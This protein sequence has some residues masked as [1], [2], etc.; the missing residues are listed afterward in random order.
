IGHDLPSFRESI[1]RKSVATA[2]FYLFDI[3]IT[4]YLQNAGPIK[5]RS[6][7]FGAAFEAYVFHELRAYIDYKAPGG[8]LAYWRSSTGFEVDF[9]LNGEI[10]IEAKA[11]NTVAARDLKG[12]H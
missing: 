10:A 12:L 6:P 3:G 8:S 7:D 5:P 1:K 2:K 9:I 4:R 11:K